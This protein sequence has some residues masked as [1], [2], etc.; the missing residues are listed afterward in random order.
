MRMARKLRTNPRKL[1]SQERSRATVD[2]LLEATTRVLI[3]EG[4]DRASTN[5][6]AEVAGVSIGSL[7][8]YFPSKEALV[9]A[10][11][12]RHTQ[13][14]SEVTRKV[15]VNAAIPSSMASLRNRSRMLGG[16]KMSRLMSERVM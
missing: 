8:Q 15:L 2:A 13:E 10:V 14:I 16:S 7:Y 3:K 5:R 6:I 11:I 9:A 4:Y 12:D 1:A